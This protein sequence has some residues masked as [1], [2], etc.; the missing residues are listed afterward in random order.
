VKLKGKT[1]LITGASK[2]IGKGIAERFAEEGAK[3]V[4][5]SRS[6]TALNEVKKELNGKGYEDVLAHPVDVRDPDSVE[7]M[8]EMTVSYFGRLDIMVNNAGV[9]MIGP[10]ESLSTKDWCFAIETDLYGVFFGCQSA[11]NR[12]I[13]QKGGGCIINISSIYGELAAP[14]RAAYCASKA[15]VNMLTK[16]LAA[17]WSKNGIRVNAIAP[18]YIRTDL[19]QRAIDQGLMQLEPLIRRTPQ[20]RIGEVVDIAELA[21]YL[22]SDLSSFMTGTI[23]VMDGGWSAYGYV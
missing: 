14:G 19:M 17:E 12:M 6:L 5:A 7:A 15:G 21:V 2:G 8:V 4:I 13:R 16:V 9:S 11:A 3:V 18:G 20:R 1:A 22:A 23:V 10:S